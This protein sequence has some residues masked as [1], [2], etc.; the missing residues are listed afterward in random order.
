[1]PN[2]WQQRAQQAAIVAQA[3]QQ[4]VD[5]R[6]RCW[7]GQ[8]DACDPAARAAMEQRTAR[9]AQTQQQQAEIAAQTQQQLAAVG[10]EQQR[11]AE[12]TSKPEWQACWHLANKQQLERGM[13][14]ER[15][16]PSGVVNLRELNEYG[17]DIQAETQYLA[18]SKAEFLKQRG[19]PFTPKDCEGNYP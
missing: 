8:L 14:L 12:R 17:Q 4:Q 19:R 6:I 15:A 18:E 3:Q 11:N 1:V 13:A 16:N 2:G 7:Q 10:A 9:I 5:P